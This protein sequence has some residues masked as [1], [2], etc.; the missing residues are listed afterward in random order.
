MIIVFVEHW[1]LETH[2]FH[3]PWG[4]YT[5]TFQDI[6]YHLVLHDND[7]PVGGCFHDFQTWYHTGTWELVERLLGVRPPAVVQQETQRR[8]AFSLKLTWLWER[9]RQMPPDT[10]DPDTLRQCAR[11]YIMLMI[12]GYLLTDNSNNTVHL[13]WFPLLDDFERCCSFS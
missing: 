8:E 9:V 12:G 10:T 7:E 4:E 5:I 1:R 3:M 13:W 6:V 2:T 11:S